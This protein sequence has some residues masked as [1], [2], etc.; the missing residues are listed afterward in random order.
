MH[1][2][3][4]VGARPGIAQRLQAVA[5]T[6]GPAG[7]TA[8]HHVKRILRKR[9]KKPVAGGNHHQRSGQP[10]HLGE[11]RQRVQHQ[12]LAGNQLVLLGPWRSRTA[13]LPGARNQRKKKSL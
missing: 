8:R 1:Q 3:P 6:V 12:G 13:A 5:H 10:R 11:S 7:A 9:L 4:V 2:H